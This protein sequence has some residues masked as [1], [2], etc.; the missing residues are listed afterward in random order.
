MALDPASVDEVWAAA[1]WPF[2]TRGLRRFYVG[3]AAGLGA[4]F[5][6]FLPAVLFGLAFDED[7]R[8]EALAIGAPLFA[9]GLMAFA[10]AIVL[11][12]RFAPEH[13]AEDAL[14]ARGARVTGHL[15]KW[16]YTPAAGNIP[17]TSHYLFGG[18]APD[19]APVF[20][21]VTGRNGIPLGTP[22]TI[23]YDPA[24]PGAGVVVESVSALRRRARSG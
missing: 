21:R 24:R 6:M 10:A 16:R 4:F 8:G 15:L 12:R 9:V 7:N 20:A 18:E 11:H 3:L 1:R 13:R 22:A 5:W 2:T 17:L 19:G 23:A 14:K